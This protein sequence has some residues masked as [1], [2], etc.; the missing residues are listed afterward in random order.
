MTEFKKESLYELSLSHLKLISHTCSLSVRQYLPVYEI[1]IMSRIAIPH[2]PLDRL[3]I[4]T[5]LA[6]TNKNERFSLSKPQVINDPL[7]NYLEERQ[8][9]R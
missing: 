3:E 2:L 5:F 9:L 6:L 4:D 7:S 8:G 1:I